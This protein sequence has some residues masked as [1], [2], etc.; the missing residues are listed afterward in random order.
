MLASL[1]L[2]AE[3]VLPAVLSELGEFAVRQVV[4]TGAHPTDASVVSDVP[5]RLRVR[6]PNL[7]G[8][9]DATRQLERR[10]ASLAGVARAQVNAATGSVLIEYDPRLTTVE[11]VYAA[12]RE[13]RR[14][15]L[16]S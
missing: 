16:P 1:I 6:V 14:L 10:L 8:E 5:G 12:T 9:P 3:Y 2:D 11:R 7:R 4:S 13:W 15:C